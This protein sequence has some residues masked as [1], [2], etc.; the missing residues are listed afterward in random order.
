MKN[1]I[2]LAFLVMFCSASCTHE[3][4]LFVLENLEI[5]PNNVSVV[6]GESSR[7]ELIYTPDD[8]IGETPIWSSS[9]ESVASI[10]QDGVVSALECGEAVITAVASGV[11]ATCKVNVVPSIVG[12]ISLSSDELNLFPSE[13][14]KLSVTSN[15]EDADLSMLVWNTSDAS[16]AVVSQ[17]GIV[18]A[19]ASG[20]AE[21]TASVGAASAVCKVVVKTKANVGDFYYSD[22]TWS[23][24]FD[25]S[26]TVV[27]VV[28]YAGNPNVDDSA[29]RKQC[30]DCKNGIAIGLTEEEMI[31]HPEYLSYQSGTGNDFIQDWANINMP[32][33]ETLKTG[34]ARGDNGNFML[35][36]NNTKVLLAFNN[37][38]ENQAWPL[39][40]MSKLIEYREANPLPDNT[41]GWYLPSIKELHVLSEGESDYNI[42][43]NTTRTLT[44]KTIVNA[45]LSKVP[46]ASIIA[47]GSKTWY[48]SSTENY[49]NGQMCF[50]DLNMS[51]LPG[52][53]V[54]YAGTNVV[55]F[56]FAF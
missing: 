42:F 47:G 15:P 50:L 32:D 22:G 44:N 30:P 53:M 18:T 24:D 25:E 23:S 5:S 21:I 56:V 27:G 55:R 52:G 45:S 17:D 51:I 8:F 49:M 3:K 1:T 36:Y 28:F 26:K 34:S 9:N 16:V 38:E 2:L 20:M 12:S 31:F 54:M 6:K 14:T 19:V 48:W 33:Y 41:S 10:N 40:T 46:G 37:D 43:W 39:L 7:L 29:L 35:G 11:M 13:S 4:T